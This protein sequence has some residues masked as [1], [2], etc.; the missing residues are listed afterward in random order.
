VLV[1]AGAVV[2]AQA[3]WLLPWLLMVAVFTSVVCRPRHAGMLATAFFSALWMIWPVQPPTGG[4][5]LWL[6]RLTLLLLTTACLEQ[7]F[8]TVHAVRA[9]VHGAY[10]GDPAAAQ[11]LAI[12]AAGKR[13]AGFGYDSIG[14]EAW[15]SG[16]IYSN[17]PHAYW[18]WSRNAR[19]DERAPAVIA[20]HPDFVVYGGAE[21]DPREGDLID[22]WYRADEPEIPLSD[23]YGVVAW[24]E[25]HGYGET[26]RFCGRAW[27]RSGSAE[28]LC[29]VILE[30]R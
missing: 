11:F 5:R 25:A 14:P 23:T 12:H 10:C 29:Q 19:V 22:D 20:T 1:V 13:V 15:F 6:H 2:S 28:E 9:D 8:W 16:P 3:R 4:A 21:V 24:A 18:L 7:V 30:P 26:H 17:Q 27:M